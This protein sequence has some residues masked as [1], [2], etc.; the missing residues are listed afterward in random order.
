MKT[1]ANKTIAA[2]KRPNASIV[3]EL[4]FCNVGTIKNNHPIND[5]GIN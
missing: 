3:V 1:I 2:G 5:A 4:L